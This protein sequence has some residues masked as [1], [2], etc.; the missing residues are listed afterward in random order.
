MFKRKTILVALIGAVFLCLLCTGMVLASGSERINDNPDEM[1]PDAVGYYTSKDGG[2]HWIV[3]GGDI[4]IVDFSGMTREEIFKAI[5]ISPEDEAKIVHEI[6]L[7]PEV[8]ID[9]VLYKSEDIH[10]FDGQQLGFTVG[11]DGRLYAFTTEEGL[12]EFQEEQTEDEISGAGTGGAI[13]SIDPIYTHY[14]EDWFCGGAVISCHYQ[15]SLANMPPGWDNEISSLEVAT[16]CYSTRLY[17]Y[18]NFGGDY[19]EALAGTTYSVLWFQGW[20]DRASST[21]HIQN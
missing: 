12:Q 13:R 11:K 3:P 2:F 6:P 8:I 18:V 15:V 21:L 4:D 10:K 14:F 16:S 20:N 1:P 5:Q 7:C 9:G 17:D 19:F